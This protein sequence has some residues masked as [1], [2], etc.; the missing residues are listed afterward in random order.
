MVPAGLSSAPSALRSSSFVVQTESIEEALARGR[1]EG[2][3]TT[4]D[5]IITKTFFSSLIGRSPQEVGDDHIWDVLRAW[6][7]RDQECRLADSLSWR[8]TKTQTL[9]ETAKLTMMRLALRA[10]DAE[11]Q[12]ASA[13]ERELASVADEERKQHL[14]NEQRMTEKFRAPRNAF[15]GSEDVGL[16][17]TLEQKGLV[18]LAKGTLA[19]AVRTDVP[20][21][22]DVGALFDR[23]ADLHAQRAAKVEEQQSDTEKKRI[24]AEAPAVKPA[25]ARST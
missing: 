5:A 10:L 17:D 24:A 22:P 15:G 2:D 23:L 11:G 21:P 3:P 18:S 20:Q 4:I 25:L 1:R 9:S 13:R 14:Y 6:L 12:Q 16:D 8:A 7:S 19:E